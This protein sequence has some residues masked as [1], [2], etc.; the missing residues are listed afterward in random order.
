[1]T[2]ATHVSRLLRPCFIAL[3]VPA[4][5]SA[6]STRLTPK[7]TEVTGRTVE[8]VE[9]GRGAATVVFESGFGDDWSPWDDVAAEVASR[10][11]VFAYSRPGYGESDP[12][13]EPRDAA[14]IVE[15]LRDL[16]EARGF[17]PPYVLVGHSFGGTYME[18]FAKLYPDEVAGLVLVDPRHRDFTT[19]CADA[20]LQG[21]TIPD[22]VVASLPRV[23]IAEFEA[24]A[25]TT[26]EIG[27]LAFGPA[28]VRVLTATSHPWSSAI[29]ALWRAMLGSLAAE[30]EDGEQVVFRG[31]GHYLQTERP[32]E[33][34]REILDLLPEL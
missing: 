15:D 23:Q 28:P 14:T 9:A 17:T 13:P 12:S 24:F 3:L 10:A 22:S 5:L 6:C 33:V 31:A 11:K 1:M 7:L 21:C 29:E 18:L 26:Q 4:A 25:S 30:A 27:T 16:L 8:V 19:A 32:H 20:G 34:A 2:D